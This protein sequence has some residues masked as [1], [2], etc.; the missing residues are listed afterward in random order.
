MV[1]AGA[2]VVLLLGCGSGRPITLEVRTD[3][4][5]ALRDYVEESFEAE[6]LDID[7]RFTTG[8]TEASLAELRDETTGATAGFDVW[9]GADASALQAAGDDG[10][11]L[12]YRPGWLDEPALVEPDADAAWHPWL[13]TPYV[14]AFSREHLELS[15]AP[16]DWNDLRH[17]R[18]AEDIE[19]LDPTRSESGAWF[20]LSMLQQ[21]AAEG[22]LDAGFDWLGDLDGQVEAYA[23]SSTDAIRGLA[24]GMSRLAIVTRADAEAARADDAPWLYYRMAESGTPIFTRGIAVVRG[25]DAVEA[26]EAFVEHV[27]TLEV[28]TAAKLETR[29]QPAFGEIDQARVPTDFELG[30]SWRP[31]DLAVDAIEGERTDW[32]DRWEREVRVR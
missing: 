4:P 22:D 13:V 18:W 20:M 11:L 2:A 19:V 7:V 9:W 24:A 29:W 32:L 14:I 30:Q 25:T 28:R 27:G 12:P 23:A 16:T 21:R 5:E 26:A 6:H 17:F 15:R 1:I 3:L 31:F 10:F 8:P